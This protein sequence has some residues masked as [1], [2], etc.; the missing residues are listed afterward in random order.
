M[1]FDFLIPAVTFTC[2]MAFT[3]GPNN[4]MLTA[5]GVNFGY[6]RTLPHIAGI[7]LGMT[8]MI[9]LAGFGLGGF[10]KA[11]PEAHSALRVVGAAY[12][13]FLAYKISTAASP[14]DGEDD[15]GKPLTPV[16]AALFQWVNPKGWTFILALV[17]TFTTAEH[18]LLQIVLFVLIN[19]I[20]TFTATSS[21]TLFGHAIGR[22]LTGAPRR[23]RMFNM[24]MGL[25]LVATVIPMALD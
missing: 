12:L 15:G 14:G 22:F 25:L 10:F 3:P 17:A 21:W 8:T 16:Q 1:L 24:V 20:V 23:L 2:V 18:Y 7:L 9:A 11:Y 4:I 6:V 13:L 19:L 5:S